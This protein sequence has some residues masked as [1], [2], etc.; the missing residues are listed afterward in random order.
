VPAYYAIKN[1]WFPA[2]ASGVSLL[3]H[4]GLAP[5]FMK[6]SGLEGLVLSSFLSAT[7]NSVLLLSFYPKLVGAFDYFKLLVH[8]MKFILAGAGLVVCLQVYEPL[9][10]WFEGGVLLQA[11]ALALT[12]LSGAVVYGVLS[13]VLKAE[14]MKALSRPKSDIK[15]TK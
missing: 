9:V 3:M 13:F 8:I 5:L 11:L 1:T 12:I 6:S 7:L 4:I 2:V 14:E 15:I 10:A